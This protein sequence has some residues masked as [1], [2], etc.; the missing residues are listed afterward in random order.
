MTDK[1][2]LTL[3]DFRKMLCPTGRELFDMLPQI[4][5]SYGAYGGDFEDDEWL[6][7]E[8][9]YYEHIKNC[10]RCKL[11]TLR[12]AGAEFYSEVHH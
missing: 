4:P 1:N 5:S 2:I 11:S 3:S 9:A 10:E 12:Y 8:R 7:E 6:P